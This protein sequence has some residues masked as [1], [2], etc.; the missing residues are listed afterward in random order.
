MPPAVIARLVV[1]G[2]YGQ[3]STQ[4]GTCNNVLQSKHLA[5]HDI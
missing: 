4:E 2:L 1:E 5:K 3:T